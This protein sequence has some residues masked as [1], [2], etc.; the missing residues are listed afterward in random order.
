MVNI[1]KH[2]FCSADTDSIWSHFQSFVRFEGGICRDQNRHPRMLD[3]PHQIKN[4]Y[5]PTI[6]IRPLHQGSKVSLD[7]CSSHSSLQETVEELPVST[8]AT[9]PLMTRPVIPSKVI[10]C[11]FMI[12]TVPSRSQTHS[13]LRSIFNPLVEAPKEDQN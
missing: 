5:S 1:M 7:S 6:Q 4:L 2:H 12:Q 8:V 3:Q 9:S 13:L 11:P 10:S